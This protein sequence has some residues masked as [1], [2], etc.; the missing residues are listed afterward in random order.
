M[1]S[2]IPAEADRG[3][4][5]IEGGA[6]TSQP[7]RGCVPSGT[8]APALHHLSRHHGWALAIEQA[9][10][11]TVSLMLWLSAFGGDTAL[12]LPRAAAGVAGL[13]MTSMHMT[14]LGALIV[15][16][17]RDLYAEICGTAPDLSGQQI[18]GMLMLGIGTPVY[19]IA[20]LALTGLSLRERGAA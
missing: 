2:I 5:C 9:S 12:R 4:K 13:L 16:A 11:L 14:L 15:L 6:D 18:G 20:G 19:L 1:R 17:P 8:Y 10:F 3:P 7:K